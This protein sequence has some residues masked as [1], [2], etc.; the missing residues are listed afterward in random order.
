MPRCKNAV[1]GKS[2]DARIELEPVA[3]EYVAGMGN[4]E[5]QLNPAMIP[6]IKEIWLAPQRPIARC[7][8]GRNRGGYMRFEKKQEMQRLCPSCA[9]VAYAASWK[10]RVM[11]PASRPPVS[12]RRACAC[13]NPRQVESH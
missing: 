3:T 8:M 12:Y 4:S 2:F 9:E 5:H 10:W 13:A 6:A 11:R 1:A 7:A